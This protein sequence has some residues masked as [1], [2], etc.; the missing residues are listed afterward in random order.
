MIKKS[1]KLLII[2]ILKTIQTRDTISFELKNFAF[3][4]TQNDEKIY[5]NIEEVLGMIF[6]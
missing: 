1:I 2:S 5:L 4:D 3:A 6:R